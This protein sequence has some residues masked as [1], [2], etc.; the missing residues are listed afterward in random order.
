[1]LKGFN[2]LYISRGKTF[3]KCFENYLKVYFLRKQGLCV[4]TFAFSYFR[5]KLFH[6]FAWGFR[7]NENRIQQSLGANLQFQ[8]CETSVRECFFSLW[9]CMSSFC[10]NSNKFIFS[11]FII[12]NWTTN[13]DPKTNEGSGQVKIL[14][15][16]HFSDSVI[17]QA[18]LNGLSKQEIQSFLSLRIRYFMKHGLF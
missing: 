6:Y 10:C 14:R 13:I 5:D 7:A 4:G 15:G 1:M 11:N 2:F 3:F 17:V 12:N 9:W 18:F 8:E 16:N